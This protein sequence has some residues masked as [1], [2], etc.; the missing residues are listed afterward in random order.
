[1]KER[2]ITA[3]IIIAVVLPPL[4]YGSW[5]LDLLIFAFVSVGADEIL[6]VRQKKTPV[7]VLLGFIM[8]MIILFLLPNNLLLVGLI[9]SLILLY[10]MTICFSWFSIDDVGLVYCM[11]NIVVMAVKC[12]SQI[13]KISPLIMMFILLATYLTDTG[14]YF[15]GY[16]FGKHKLNP[17]ISPKKTIEGSIGGWILGAIGSFLFAY[18]YLADILPLEVIVCGSVLM[19]IIGQI[20]D[21]ALSAIKRHYQ[22]KDFG[23]IFP[24]HG[25]VLDRIDSLLF[26]LLLFYILMIGMMI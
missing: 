13:Y 4:L 7:W 16:F 6:K 5:L 23:K 2:M 3:I 14:A 26:N 21:L 10:F 18:F 17:R 19:P 25:G 22:V 11:M 24:G 15:C 9:V 8:M 1:M 20:G 12:I